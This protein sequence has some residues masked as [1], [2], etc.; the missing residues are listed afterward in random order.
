MRIFALCR[1]KFDSFTTFGNGPISLAVGMKL[2]CTNVHHL[3]IIY[4]YTR[5]IIFVRNSGVYCWEYI[6][7]CYQSDMLLFILMFVSAF[8]YIQFNENVLLR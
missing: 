7:C 1:I 4:E 5:T 8:S 2:N 6:F 3:C